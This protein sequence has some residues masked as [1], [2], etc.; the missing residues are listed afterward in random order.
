MPLSQP[1]ARKEIHTR[2]ICCVGY[3]REDGLWDIEGRI[4]DTKTYSFKNQDRG[5]VASGQPIHDMVIRL[6]VDDDLVVQEA[7]ASTEASPYNICPYITGN[8]A[9]LKGLKIT[10]GWTKAVRGELGGVNGCTHI[11]QM[12]I[13]PLATTAYQTIIPI[14]N[15][16]S[17]VKK[18]KSKPAIIGTCHAY[19]ADGEIV[20]RLWPEYAATE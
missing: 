15:S 12:I 11:S 17:K 16:H 6:T 20:K 1:V 18:P 9:R 10:A 5:L 13:G 3:E 8:I 14:K 4:T 19:A 7:E 2:E